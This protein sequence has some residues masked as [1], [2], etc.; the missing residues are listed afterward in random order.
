MPGLDYHI[1]LVLYRRRL[2]DSFQ[3]TYWVACANCRKL[4]GPYPT[5]RAAGEAVARM[6]DEFCGENW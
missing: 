3:R 1:P 2:R 6:S 4:S 5:M